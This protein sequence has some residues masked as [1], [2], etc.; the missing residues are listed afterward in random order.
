MFERVFLE[1]S[2]IL[3]VAFVVA[4]FVNNVII[5]NSYI[6]T[7]SMGD[8]KVEGWV[9]DG[10]NVPAKMQWTPVNFYTV[11]EPSSGIMLVFGIAILLLR[12]NNRIS[13]A[14]SSK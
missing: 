12:R 14:I 7:P 9:R 1:W 6:P 5:T 11:P 13:R 8:K 10:V 2:G 4:I 3:V